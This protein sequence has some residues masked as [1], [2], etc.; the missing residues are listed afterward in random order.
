[1]YM[2]V[3]DDLG[4]AEALERALQ[5]GQQGLEGLNAEEER[6]RRAHALALMQGYASLLRQPRPVDR[7]PRR[8]DTYWFKLVFPDGRWSVDEQTLPQPPQDGDVLAIGQQEW[9][10]KGT[11][12]VMPRPA[13]KPARDF[14]VCAPVS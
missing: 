4:N 2:A 12:R 3:R 7:S 8:L 14:V 11:Q 9:L 10:V 13:G 5:A 1:M 6:E